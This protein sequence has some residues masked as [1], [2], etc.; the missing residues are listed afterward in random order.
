ML[1][2]TWNESSRHRLLYEY[3]ILR[4]ILHSPW[5]FDRTLRYIVPPVFVLVLAAL[6][7][8]PQ[9]RDHNAALTVFWAGLWPAVLLSFPFLGRIWYV[10]SFVLGKQRCLCC[11]VD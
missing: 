3:P 4:K 8:G 5:V 2:K 10:R 9:T 6:M 11:R 1:V 7:C